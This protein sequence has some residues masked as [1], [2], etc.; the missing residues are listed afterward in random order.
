MKNAYNKVAALGMQIVWR[1]FKKVGSFPGSNFS[2]K[3]C[4][5]MSIWANQ[6]RI[7]LQYLWRKKPGNNL[8]PH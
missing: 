8:I 6:I 5:H 7:L 2:G 3:I 4:L 1:E